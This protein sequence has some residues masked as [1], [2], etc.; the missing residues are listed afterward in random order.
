MLRQ[1]DINE[2]NEY[3]CEFTDVKEMSPRK[4][5]MEPSKRYFDN[6]GNMVAIFDRTEDEFWIS[7]NAPRY[8]I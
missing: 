4:S 1:V 3:V 5:L 6:D 7:D 2:F 8:S